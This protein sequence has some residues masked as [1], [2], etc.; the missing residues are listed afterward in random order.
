MTSKY[1]G[2]KASTNFSV[3]QNDY[4]VTTEGGGPSPRRHNQCKAA[5][6]TPLNCDVR[7]QFSEGRRS[8]DF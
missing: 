2:R 1:K 4:M 5:S 8:F 7:P 3:I 6:G